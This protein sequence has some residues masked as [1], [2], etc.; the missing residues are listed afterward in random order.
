[1]V[2]FT[3][4]LPFRLALLKQHRHQAALHATAIRHHTSNVHLPGAACAETA[5]MKATTAFTVFFMFR[6]LHHLDEV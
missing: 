3:L 4:S 6:L 1:M 2:E 5:D